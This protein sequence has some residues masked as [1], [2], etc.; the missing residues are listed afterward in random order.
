MRFTPLTVTAIRSAS[1]GLAL[2]A[3]ATT[4]STAGADGWGA[5]PIT[6]EQRTVDEASGTV[7]HTGNA[8][9]DIGI[10]RVEAQRI[11]EHRADGAIVRLSASG[12]PIV[13]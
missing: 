1:L 13:F 2:L 8:V 9:L 6:A 3:L 12:D 10:L 4:A 11:T 7:D 5:L